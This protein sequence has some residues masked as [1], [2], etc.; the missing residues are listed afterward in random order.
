MG[1]WKEE[2]AAEGGGGRFMGGDQ[3]LVET[4][5]R[6]IMQRDLGVSFD[7]IACLEDAKRLLREAVIMPVLL[8]EFFTGLRQPWKG[9]LLHGPPGTGK[10]MLAKA[11]A[12]ASRSTFFNVSSSTLVS[13]YRGESEKLVSILFAMARHYAPSIIFFDEVDALASSR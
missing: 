11:V 13:K 4:I 7:D 1:T 12:C 6:G 8:P 5:E 10:T 3:A 9:V 2:E